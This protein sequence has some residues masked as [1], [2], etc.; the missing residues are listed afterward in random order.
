MLSNLCAPLRQLLERMF[1]TV[2][3]VYVGSLLNSLDGLHKFWSNKHPM[4]VVI[5]FIYCVQV[6]MKLQQSRMHGLP[7]S[8]GFSDSKDN[9][10]SI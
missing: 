3:E 8:V 6:G 10:I 1:E 7:V 4:N 2:R 5:Q 9:G